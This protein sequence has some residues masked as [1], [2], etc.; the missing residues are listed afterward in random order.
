MLREDPEE[1]SC[2]KFTLQWSLG[3]NSPGKC[4]FELDGFEE[5]NDEWGPPSDEKS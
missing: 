3:D 4:M 1:V 2:G 5:E